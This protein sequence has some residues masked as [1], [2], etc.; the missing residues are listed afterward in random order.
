M[1]IKTLLSAFI[2]T[3]ALSCTSTTAPTQ[4]N[5]SQW[6]IDS[7]TLEN[8][9]INENKNLPSG[10]AT[11]LL[12]GHTDRVNGIHHLKELK[13]ESLQIIALKFEKKEELW[14]NQVHYYQFLFEDK[15][16]EEQFE[17]F[18]NLMLNYQ[19]NSK[20]QVSFFKRNATWYLKFIPMP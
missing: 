10:I 9:V 1:T 16:E 5:Q 15:K 19:S 6:L 2:I 13:V 3:T 12:R 14:T 17:R 18:Q 11:A 20:N 8:Y 4:E 7:L